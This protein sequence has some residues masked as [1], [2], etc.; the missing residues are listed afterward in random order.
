MIFYYSIT[1]VFSYQKVVNYDIKVAPGFF[2]YFQSFAYYRASMR[3]ELTGDARSLYRAQS[4]E[5]NK[6]KGQK[7]IKPKSR[8]QE[9][10]KTRNKEQGAAAQLSL[11]F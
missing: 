1:S 4:T 5:Q 9:T 7:I 10:K 6:V 8:A 11:L 2:P 3:D